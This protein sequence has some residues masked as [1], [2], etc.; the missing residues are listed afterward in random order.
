MSLK[1]WKNPSRGK[2]RPN[3][4]KSG[5]DPLRHRQYK[6]WVQQ[7]NQAQFRGE[8]WSISFDQWLAIWGDMWPHRGRERGC[9]CMS[10]IDWS[11]PWTVKNVAI[12]TREQ[13]ARMQVESRNAGWRSPAQK[14]RRQKLGLTT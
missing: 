8:G 10:R 1:G 5:T 3:S 4:W 7:R 13:H 6:I 9:Y 14:F 11:L 12:I 2:E